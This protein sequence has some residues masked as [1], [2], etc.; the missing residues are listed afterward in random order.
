M[1]RVRRVSGM[2]HWGFSST[3]TVE[4][5]SSVVWIGL[6]N[7]ALWSEVNPKNIFFM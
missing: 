6:K 1:Q 2:F 4:N 3:R 5:R 7:N